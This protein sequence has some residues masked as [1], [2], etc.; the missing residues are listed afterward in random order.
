MAQ[1]A[2]GTIYQQKDLQKFLQSL[3]EAAQAGK[4]FTEGKTETPAKTILD[5]KRD[6]QGKL[7][8]QK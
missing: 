6:T 8:P 4:D 1:A 2:E 7:K 5:F 3:V